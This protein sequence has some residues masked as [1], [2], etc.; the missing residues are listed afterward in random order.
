MLA[1]GGELE[2]AAAALLAAHLGEVGQE[3]LLELVAARRSGERDVLLAPEVGDRL[4]E[5]VDGDDV[6]AGQRRLGRRL[7]GA[8]E[9][10]QPGPP[11]PLGDGDRARDG[12]HATVERELADAAV[13]EQPRRRE[14]VGAGEHARARSAGRTPIPPCAARRARG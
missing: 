12:P 14:L 6:D 4:G 13:L 10:R 3:R 7:G 5:V 9:P 8:E 2:R 11:R 1:G